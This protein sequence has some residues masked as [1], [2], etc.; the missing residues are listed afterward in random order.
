MLSS[1]IVTVTHYRP[2]VDKLHSASTR[3]VIAVGAGGHGELAQRGGQA[4][5][6]LLGTKPVTFPGDHGG[7]LGGEYGQTGEPDAFAERLRDVLAATPDR[8]A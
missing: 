8:V 4:V 3:I 7:F 5:A 1:N 2:D 6:E